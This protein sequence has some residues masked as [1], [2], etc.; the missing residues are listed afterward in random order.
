MSCRV[1][2]T[3]LL[4][5]LLL[6]ACASTGTP[7]ETHRSGMRN[8]KLYLQTEKGYSLDELTI[9]GKDDVENIEWGRFWSDLEAEAT[10]SAAMTRWNDQMH[11]L[12]AVYF[13]P[14]DF[15]TQAIW[16]FIDRNTGEV[17]GSLPTVKLHSK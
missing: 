5:T 17:A 11:T 14:V 15:D 4:A 6:S 16:V 13:N 3:L 8:A 7:I 9:R 10:P 1:V 2:T 12:Y